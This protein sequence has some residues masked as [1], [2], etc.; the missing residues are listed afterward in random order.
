MRNC[1]SRRLS[2]K[3]IILKEGKNIDHPFK[4]IIYLHKITEKDH[5]KVTDL[6]QRRVIAAARYGSSISVA[7]EDMS[8]FQ[9]YYWLAPEDYLGKRLKT[10]FEVKF[11]VHSKLAIAD[12][13]PTVKI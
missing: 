9:A 1:S 8:Q 11:N 4:H 10:K 3:S 7:Q 2:R 13:R 6:R 5:W 12:K